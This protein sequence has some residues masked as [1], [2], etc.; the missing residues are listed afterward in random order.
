[1]TAIFAFLAKPAGRW[2]AAGVAALLLLW[3]VHHQGYASG[4]AD[5]QAAA[6]KVEIR[7]I[8]AGTAAVRHAETQATAG[9]IKDKSNQ[10]IIRYVVKTVAA[11][12][13]AGA[14]CVSAAVADSLRNLQ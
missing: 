9:A 7:Q 14:E 6:R 1:M 11:Q 4:R 2:I 12:P 10:E 3:G 13:D 5:C 8:E